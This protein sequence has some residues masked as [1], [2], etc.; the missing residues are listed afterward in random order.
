M[1]CAKVEKLGILEPMQAQVTVD[2]VMQNMLGGFQAV[3]REK[4]KALPGDTLAELAATDEL[5]L[6]YLHLQSMRNF[7]ALR[8]RMVTSRQR[9]RPVDEPQTEPEAM[10]EPVAP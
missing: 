8:D 7:E 3:S 4:L 10:P 6:I 5:E 2:G 9:T 1:F